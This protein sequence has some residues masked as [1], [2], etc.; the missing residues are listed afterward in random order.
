MFLHQ[1]V[2]TLKN[3]GP[4]GWPRPLRNATSAK[5]QAAGLKILEAPVLIGSEVSEAIFWASSASSLVWAV[6]VSTCFLACDDH[7]S[8][9]A[10]GDLVL[11]SSW[12]KSN[13]ALVLVFTMSSS[14][15]E[16]SVAPLVAVVKTASMVELWVSAAS[17]NLV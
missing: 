5:N 1:T 6:K 8:M 3:K 15:A 4:G 12:A 9:A 10:D 14:L 17:L 11:T 2:P 7:S 16:Y 13:A